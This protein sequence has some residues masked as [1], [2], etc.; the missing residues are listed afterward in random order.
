MCTI[1][2]QFDTKEDL[3]LV[4]P[5][6]MTSQCLYRKSMIIPSERPYTKLVMWKFS[7]R[8]NDCKK[9]NFTIM[10]IYTN[11]SHRKLKILQYMSDIR[12]EGLAVIDLRS[13]FDLVLSTSIS[14]LINLILFVWLWPKVVRYGL[15]LLKLDL[16]LPNNPKIKIQQ[17]NRWFKKIVCT[18]QW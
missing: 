18:Y 3:T 6:L 8:L 10:Y 5:L 17:D 11:C 4:W 12:L 16:G 7:W 13:E 15:G 1:S 14:T 2:V 9:R